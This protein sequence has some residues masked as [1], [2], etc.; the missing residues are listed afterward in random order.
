[1]VASYLL[2]GLRGHR[3]FPLAVRA[4]GAPVHLRGL[5]RVG[6]PATIIGMMFS[7]VYIVFARAASH[8]GPAAM[9]V[10]GIVNRVE[11]LQFIASLAIGTAG[12]ALVGQNLGAG[13]PDRADQVLRTGLSWNLWI[14]GTLTL[15]LWAF[16]AT[17]L[18]LFTRDPE[19]LR[20]GVPYLRILTLCL[21][22]NGMEI[23]VSESILG[24]GHTRAIS[25]IFT[26]FSLLRIPLALWSPAWGIGALG[27]AWII[28]GTCLVRGLIIV[29]WA[30]RGTW[31]RGLGHELQGEP[32]AMA[33]PPPS[34]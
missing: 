26:S 32:S 10:V 24:S 20:I 1:M 16:P 11:A 25:W 23:V 2:V 18:G 33:S 7:V 21:V 9:A 13:R 34:A 27:I 12:A 28:T 19:A 15:L 30:S 29:A 17:F 4:E 14:S 22:V 3:A 6:I 5:V 31:K 8:F